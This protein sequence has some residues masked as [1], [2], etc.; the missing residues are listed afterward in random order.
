MAT[1]SSPAQPPRDRAVWIAAVVGLAGGLMLSVPL[2]R[3]LQGDQTPAAPQTRSLQGDQTP[4]APQTLSNPFGSW[5]GFGVQDVV[6]LGRDASGSNTDTIFTLRVEGGRTVITQIPRDSYV[7]ADGFGAMKINGLLAA[8]GPEA[9][10]R[11][12]TRLMDRP[13][14][15]HIVVK[16]DAISTLADLVGGIEVD[17]PK[18]LYYVDRSQGLVIDLQPGKQLLKGKELEGF[19]RWR[20]DGRGD[21]GRLERQQL[22]L[23]ALFERIKQPQ[24]LIRLPALIAAAGN[25]L[26]TDLG[27]VE[28]G[29]L[30]T[31]IGSTDLDTKRLK[32][33]PFSRGGVSYL[34]TEWPAKD[35]SGVEASEA[36]SRRSQFLF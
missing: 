27:P 10:E 2:T 4:A 14:R 35:S 25:E 16:L 21:F 23:K 24:N 6:V 22:A 29:G 19:L 11:E 26:Q 17:V 18:R 13:I 8:G 33:T 3:S 31:A 34:D 7:N 15:H 9:V 20:N 32:A 12:L 36:S 28:L 5:A 1:P 30:V